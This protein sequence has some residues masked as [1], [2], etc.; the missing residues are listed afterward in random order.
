MPSQIRLAS[1]EGTENQRFLL[2]L[3]SIGSEERLTRKLFENE[4]FRNWQ[5]GNHRLYLFLDS[6]DE[7]LLRIDTLASLL[8]EEL[9]GCPIDRLGIRIACR[10]ADWPSHLEEGLLNP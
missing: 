2:D 7:C 4:K 1:S 6:L 5:Q 9:G 10:T 8:I 3:R